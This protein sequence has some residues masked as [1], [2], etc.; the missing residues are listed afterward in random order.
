MVGMGGRS[1]LGVE[2]ESPFPEFKKL[3]RP[4][5]KLLNDILPSMR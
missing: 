2:G 1:V 3:G 4:R 5:R